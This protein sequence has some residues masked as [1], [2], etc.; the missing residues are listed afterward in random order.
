MQRW[1]EVAYARQDG[2]TEGKTIGMAEGEEKLLIKLICRKLKKETD[3]QAIAKELEEDLERVQNVCRV[4]E[5]Y[6][7][8]YDCN[9]IYDALHKDKSEN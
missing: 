9:L 1:E 4:A 6:A 8:E 3:P 5:K 7:P 2:I